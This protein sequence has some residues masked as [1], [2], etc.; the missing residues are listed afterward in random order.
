MITSDVPGYGLISVADASVDEFRGLLGRVCGRAPT[1][2]YDRSVDAFTYCEDG[3]ELGRYYHDRRAG[4]IAAPA[5]VR[6][7]GIARRALCS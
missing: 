3:V 6:V 1:P 5:P 2:T 7:A 4:H